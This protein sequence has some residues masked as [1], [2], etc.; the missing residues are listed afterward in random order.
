MGDQ[1]W[2]A[3]RDKPGLVA[4]MMKALAGG[5]RISFEGKLSC[6]RLTALPGASGEE[7]GAL[8]RQ[9]LFPRQDFVV[10][11]LEPDTLRPILAEIMPSGRLVREIVHVQIER[12]GVLEFGSCDNVHPECV[13]SGPGVSDDLLAKLL[14]QGVLRAYEEALDPIGDVT[15]DL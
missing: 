8:T 10:L 12:G 5:S 11:P 14:A 4:A 3:A 9:T 1:H 15:P 6:C 7:A 13:V 2:L